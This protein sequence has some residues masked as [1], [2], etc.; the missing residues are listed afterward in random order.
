MYDFTD[1]WTNKLFNWI[2]TVVIK[3]FALILYQCLAV[4]CQGRSRGSMIRL[5]LMG[6]EW[7]QK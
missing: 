4:V 3:K 7:L 6:H 1:N 5:P 2:S